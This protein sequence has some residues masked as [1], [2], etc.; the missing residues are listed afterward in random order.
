MARPLRLEFAGAL[1]HVMSRGNGRAAVFVDGADRRAFLR[2]LSFVSRRLGWR[3][4]SYCLMTNHYHLLVET[5]EPSLAR[6]MHDLNGLYAQHFNRRHDHVGHVFQGRY[7]AIVVERG[8]YL[9]EL[10]RYIAL[11]PVRGGLCRRPVD[12]PW[13]SHRVV[14]GRRSP[15]LPVDCTRV[16]ARF[17][18][19]VDEARAA[20]DQFVLAGIGLP[21]PVLNAPSDEDSP[22]LGSAG[23]RTEVVEHC[24]TPSAEV[25]RK[26]RASRQLSQY[27]A[28]APSRDAAILA[29]YASGLYSL[30]AI[31]RYFGLH[32]STISKICRIGGLTGA[33]KNRRQMTTAVDRDR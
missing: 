26:Q 7:R 15:G 33:S 28:E 4:L 2:Q 13:S 21:A 3:F 14:L 32:Y 9:V 25:P 29:A 30:A 1:Y 11:N 10:I 17:G 12:W 24:E 18:G 22:V 6:G 19:T 5:P 31:G 23:F 8:D 20:Y 27:Q 16:L